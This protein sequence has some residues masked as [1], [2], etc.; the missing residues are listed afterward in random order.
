LFLC[1]SINAVAK[2]QFAW[3]NKPSREKLLNT[4]ILLPSKNN[5]PDWEKMEQMAKSKY[6]YFAKTLGIN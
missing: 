2:K 1:F 4:V 3:T 5:E 6:E